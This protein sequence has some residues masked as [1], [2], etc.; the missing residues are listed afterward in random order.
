MTLIQPPTAASWKVTLHPKDDEFN[1]AVVKYPLQN[2]QKN[3]NRSPV[4]HKHGL[5]DSHTQTIK[6]NPL[7]NITVGCEVDIKKK[8]NIF[9]LTLLF[10]DPLSQ[11]LSPAFQS[12]D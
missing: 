8:Q 7:Y 6:V 12:K 9:S 5:T 2:T 3:K 11:L 10:M 4:K 1:E